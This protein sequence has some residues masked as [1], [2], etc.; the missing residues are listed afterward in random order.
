MKRKL[1][2]GFQLWSAGYAVLTVVNSV[3]QLFNAA[4]VDT[5]INILARALICLVPIASY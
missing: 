2:N 4:A 3:A 5:N 1:L